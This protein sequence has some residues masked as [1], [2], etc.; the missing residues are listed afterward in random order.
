MIDG[1]YIE[2]FHN[3]EGEHVACVVGQFLEKLAWEIERDVRV[4]FSSNVVAYQGFIK[5]KW[6]EDGI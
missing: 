5:Q 6:V 3:F 2:D 1:R 4:M